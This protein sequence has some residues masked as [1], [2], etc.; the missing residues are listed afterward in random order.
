MSSSILSFG[1][2][3]SRKCAGSQTYTALANRRSFHTSLTQCRSSRAGKTHTSSQCLPF[4]LRLERERVQDGDIRLTAYFFPFSWSTITLS[5][6]QSYHLFLSKQVSFRKDIVVW[7]C[8]SDRIIINML[9]FLFHSWNLEIPPIYF[10]KIYIQASDDT[11]F[12]MFWHVQIMAVFSW[13]MNF[14]VLRGR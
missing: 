4:L 2:T 12:C 14:P 9:Y 7:F 10:N 5:C 11:K 3:Y 8:C 1:S 13:L 6:L